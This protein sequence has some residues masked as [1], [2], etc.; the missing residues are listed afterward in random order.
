MNRK[1]A[2][3]LLATTIALTGAYQASA[4][5]GMNSEDGTASPRMGMAT[6]AQ[7]DKAT[8]EKFEVFLKETKALRKSMVEKRAEKNALMQAD[9]PDA[10]KVAALAG[11]IFELRY[12]MHLKAKAAGLVQFMGSGGHSA[13]GSGM[14]HG[15]EHRPA[16]RR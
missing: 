2:I 10:K 8:K 6:T 3:S 16:M 14:N 12:E 5:M 1:I 4:Y 9:N 15:R 11:E 13:M 7:M